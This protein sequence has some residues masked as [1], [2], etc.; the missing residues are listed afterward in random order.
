MESFRNKIEITDK[1]ASYISLKS[2]F[3]MIFDFYLYLTKRKRKPFSLKIQYF[4]LFYFIFAESKFSL[5]INFSLFIEHPL[6]SKEKN[7][8]K[9]RRSI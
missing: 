3:Y 4:I 2:S 5:T 7:K 9:S 6:K 1:I 8:V